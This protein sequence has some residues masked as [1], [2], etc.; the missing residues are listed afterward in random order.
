MNNNAVFECF[1]EEGGVR[2][3]SPRSVEAEGH[4]DEGRVSTEMPLRQ[5]NSSSAAQPK[6]EKGTSEISDTEGII[7]GSF[8]IRE[9]LH[10]NL[11]EK[12]DRGPASLPAL[13]TDRAGAAI[14]HG[15]EPCCPWWS[16]WVDKQPR[17]IFR[18]FAQTPF[19]ISVL[20]F[21]FFNE[22]VLNPRGFAAGVS[23][24]SRFPHPG[25][26]LLSPITVRNSYPKKKKKQKKKLKICTEEETQSL[27]C[28]GKRRISLENMIIYNETLSPDP[29]VTF[30][31]YG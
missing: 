27:W 7:H 13:G 29:Y 22:A 20:T 24:I 23:F 16:C 14:P 17:L 8:L 4:R 25:N 21:L 30:S 1:G 3:C 6:Q 9:A 31:I 26:Q 5:A 11:V 19:I 28:E 18:A 2:C 12:R 15:D 10:L